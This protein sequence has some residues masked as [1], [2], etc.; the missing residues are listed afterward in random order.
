[1]QELNLACAELKINHLNY[2]V[3]NANQRVEVLHS[4][5]SELIARINE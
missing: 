2:L 1:M 5:I 4:K 3:A